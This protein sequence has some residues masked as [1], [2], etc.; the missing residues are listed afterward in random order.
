MTRIIAVAAILIIATGVAAQ[1]GLNAGGKAAVHVIPHASRSCTKSYPTITGCEDIA[2][3]EPT[4]D[5]DAFPVFYELG[6]YQ[7]F[8]FSMTWPGL[9]SVV[10]TSCSDLTIGGIVFTGDGVS[11]AWTLCQ[12]TDIAVPGWAWVFDYGLVC[13]AEHPGTGF[14]GAGDCQGGSTADSIFTVW[15]AG[16]GGTAGEDPCQNATEPCTWGNIKQIFR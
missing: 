7:G 15:C 14:I 8:D 4:S 2:Y 11:H 10:Y 5:V 13:V 12:E 6:E 16:I 3:T 1:A 9:Y